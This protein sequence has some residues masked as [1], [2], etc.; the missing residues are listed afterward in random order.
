MG[1][2]RKLNINSFSE[3][4]SDIILAR[5]KTLDMWSITSI[6]CPVFYAKWHLVIIKL[7]KCPKIP[8]LPKLNNI[9]LKFTLIH[10]KL[11]GS[12]L[13]LNWDFLWKNI[14]KGTTDPRVEFIKQVQ[15]KILIKFDLQNLDQASTSKS[16]ATSAFRLNLKGSSTKKI[17]IA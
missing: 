4:S 7:Y 12:R 6:A 1:R 11:M 2:G 16:Q 15:T 8:K 9:S 3:L 14:A 10:F 5:L 17:S 13:L